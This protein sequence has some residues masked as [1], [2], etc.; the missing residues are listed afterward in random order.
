MRLLIITSIDPSNLK[1]G[2]TEAYVMNLVN[3]AVDNNVEV[4]MAGVS[5]SEK[6]YY[7]GFN[8]IPI[9]KD[10][11]VSNYKFLLYLVLKV[12]FL[13]I[14]ESSII[15]VQRPD[16]ML[17]FIF[18]NRRNVKVC[19]LHGL[20]A[21]GILLKK[22]KL[23]G[24]LYLLIEKFCLKYT[25]VLIAV[26]EGTESAY[27]KEYP[28]LKNKIKLI[29]VGFNEKKFRLM[30]KNEMREKY[31]LNR[32]DKIVLYAGRFEKEKNLDFL[33]QSFALVSKRNPDSK[34]ILVGSG[35]EKESLQTLSK[36]L[37][38]NISF[39]NP[40]EQD[41][42]AEIINCADVF[43]LAS[44][45]ESGPLAVMEALACGVPV[46]TTDVGRVREFIVTEKCGKIVKRDQKEFANAINDII[47]NASE[48]RKE[49]CRQSVINF[50]FDATAK[51]T[52]EK[53]EQINRNK[54]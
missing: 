13:R 42:L 18:F 20:P 39:V 23:I 11:K 17:P 10:A 2:G 30:D 54:N 49:L 34:L 33:L 47:N 6:L 9:I 45:Y 37:K 24:T 3:S 52:I 22:G 41:V 29:P 32:N 26:S 38:I 21:N 16:M 36:K 5:R 51:K 14:P 28:W 40:V 12:P 15:H 43:V 27:L 53:Y 8:F 35:R 46:V 44:R 4:T 7:Q 48:E 25:H 19:T 50:N 1:P 31:K